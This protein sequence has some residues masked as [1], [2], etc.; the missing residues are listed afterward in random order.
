MASLPRGC[1]RQLAEATEATRQNTGLNLILALGYSGKWDITQAARK[2]A[3][4]RTER[5]GA[6]SEVNEE[7]IAA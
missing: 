5:S 3:E 7:L 6:P 1:Q 4:R 2:I